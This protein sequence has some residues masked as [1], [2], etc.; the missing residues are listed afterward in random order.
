MNCEEKCGAIFDPTSDIYEECIQECE[1][2]NFRDELRNK[3]T[4]EVKIW[5]EQFHGTSR[6]KGR[7]RG[8]KGRSRGKKGR[9]RG[10]KGR[11]RGKKGRSRRYI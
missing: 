5:N 7:S 3:V 10:K 2:K 8:K 11:S 9:S 6:K 4:E 1:E